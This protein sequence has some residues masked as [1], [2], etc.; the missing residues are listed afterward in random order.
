MLH[1]SEASCSKVCHAVGVPNEQFELTMNMSGDFE[2]SV[3]EHSNLTTSSCRTLTPLPTSHLA[4]LPLHL[5]I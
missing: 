2:Q 1:F 3:C 5:T 4:A